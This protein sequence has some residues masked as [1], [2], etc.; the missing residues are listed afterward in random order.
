MHVSIPFIVEAKHVRKKRKC[1]ILFNCMLI[2]SAIN[3]SDRD[4]SM[5]R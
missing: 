1:M 5:L 4:D 3:G 2:V